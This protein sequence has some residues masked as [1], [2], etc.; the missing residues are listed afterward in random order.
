M[1][2][3]VCPKKAPF[4]SVAPKLLHLNIISYKNKLNEA[5]RDVELT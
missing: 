5:V 3:I 2:S 4:I 1:W